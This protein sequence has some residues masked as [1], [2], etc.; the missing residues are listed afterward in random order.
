[1]ACIAVSAGIGMTL[2]CVY[3]AKIDKLWVSTQEST[4][5]RTQWESCGRRFHFTRMEAWVQTEADGNYSFSLVHAPCPD[6][7]LKF[8]QNFNHAVCN[9]LSHLQP[10]FIFNTNNKS[11]RKRDNETEWDSCIRP[12]VN[13]HW[14]VSLKVSIYHKRI[15]YNAP[16]FSKMSASSTHQQLSTKCSFSRQ[17]KA[18]WLEQILISLLILGPNL[19]SAV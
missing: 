3:A 5:R 9:W 19:S 8:H 10:I 11:K 17:I 16:K 13:F 15:N 14:Q 2:D 4:D 7:F 6:Y 1:M 12:T 18:V